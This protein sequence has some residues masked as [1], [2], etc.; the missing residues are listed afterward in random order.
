MALTHGTPT[1][2]HM[3]LSP[4]S[5]VWC[6]G[7]TLEVNRHT[8]RHNGPSALA[9]VWLRTADQGPPSCESCVWKGL[10]LMQLSS[11]HLQNGPNCV[12]WDIKLFSLTPTDIRWIYGVANRTVFN[13]R[14]ILTLQL[15][16]QTF[17][18]IAHLHILLRFFYVYCY[19]LGAGV[20]R[21]SSFSAISVWN[22]LAFQLLLKTELFIIQ[23]NSDWSLPSSP[24]ICL[25]NIRAIEIRFE[26][27]I[28]CLFSIFCWSL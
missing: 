10:F 3:P 4:S 23:S 6:T 26:W 27:S 17:S 15:T 18:M 24:P 19:S 22:S 11:Y 16:C 2:A 21:A 13:I 20:V 8:V 25:W 12:G 9:G 1:R 28:V 7:I 14:S 5:V